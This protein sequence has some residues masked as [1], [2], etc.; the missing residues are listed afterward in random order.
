VITATPLCSVSGYNIG[1][2]GYFCPDHEILLW[3]PQ[4]LV[5]NP[6]SIPIN[7]CTSYIDLVTGFQYWFSQNLQ[8]VISP[9]GYYTFSHESLLD[10]VPHYLYTKMSDAPQY[11]KSVENYLNLKH[12]NY[13][14]YL[15]HIQ[16]NNP[17][18]LMY[19]FE[20][21]LWQ[22][23]LIQSSQQQ[24]DKIIRYDGEDNVLSVFYMPEKHC[25]VV[26]KETKNGFIL[27]NA[28][29]DKDDQDAI[30]ATIPVSQQ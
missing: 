9:L 2:N 15:F 12:G 27:R 4:S 3:N 20:G 18:I 10:G 13:R 16:Q 30:L 29:G 24:N 17:P 14:G 8:S 25:V 11:Q 1:Q 6:A 5:S 26:C 22:A 23:N 28:F 7:G 21:I 19:W